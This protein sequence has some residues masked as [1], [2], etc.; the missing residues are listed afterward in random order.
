MKGPCVYL[1]RV[2]G[3]AVPE[4][5]CEHRPVTEGWVGPPEGSRALVYL[6]WL[7]P[8]V[9]SPTLHHP[10][11]PHPTPVEAGPSATVFPFTHRSP[12]TPTTDGHPV[13]CGWETRR[14]SPRPAPEVPS[15]TMGVCREER[16]P[17][18]VPP[19]SL[20][21]SS[22]EDHVSRNPYPTTVKTRD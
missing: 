10:Q 13:V 21:P 22:R 18:G 15:T 17:Q 16:R 19:T 7:R 5:S 8:G 6:G 9:H 20:T 2:S 3:S 12:A 14:G 4:C 11:G 1:P